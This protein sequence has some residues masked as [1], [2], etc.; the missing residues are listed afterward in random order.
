ML[1]ADL[2]KGGKRLSFREPG[3]HR[4]VEVEHFP[5]FVKVESDGTAAVLTYSMC[6]AQPFPDK[7]GEGIFQVGISGK[8]NDM[9]LNI[10]HSI[11]IRSKC[12]SLDVVRYALE[13]QAVSIDIK[14]IEADGNL[15][16]ACVAGINAVISHLQLKTYFVPRVF[17]YASVCGQIVADPDAA[18]LAA[19]DW[20]MYV[21]MRSTRELL[22]TEKEGCFCSKEDILD[23]AERA[24]ADAKRHTI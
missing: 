9:L 17:S 5:S 14:V 11:Y 15:L 21:V 23:V 12:V 24:F 20:R 16:A 1:V 8:K 7:P 3:Q 13:V 6:T 19:S 2:M 4:E 22:L 10:L 18:E